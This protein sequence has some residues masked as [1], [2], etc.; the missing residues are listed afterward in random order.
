ME[1]PAKL[2]QKC[3]VPLL[4]FLA[5]ILNG[6][7]GAGGGMVAVPLLRK[8]GLSQKEAHATSIGVILPISLFSVGM[9]L[10]KGQFQ[11]EDVLPFLP[12]GILGGVIGGLLL[13]KIPSS[14]LRRIFGLLMAWAAI[15]LLMA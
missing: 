4:G 1:K 7:F 12:G 15:R 3:G 5:G 10:W 11:V 8:L 9:Y 14:I 6:L 13:P 2:L